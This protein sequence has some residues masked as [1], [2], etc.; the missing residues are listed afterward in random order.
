[1]KHYQAPQD[2]LKERVILVTGAGQGIGRV[3]ALTFAAHGATVILHGRSVKKLEA[4]YDEI[5]AAGHPQPAIFP[6]DLEKAESKDYE[7]LA[8]AIRGQLGRLDGILHNAAVAERPQRLED[9]TLEQWLTLLRVNLAAP[10]ALT[11]ACLPLLKGSPDASVIMTSETHGHA[12]AAYWGGFAV[13]KSGLETLV[14]IWSQELEIHPNVRINALIPGPVQS[15][16]R[17]RT[18]PGEDRRSLPTPESLMP[19]YLYLMGGDSANVSG[20]ILSAQ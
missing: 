18:H 13:A 16:Q 11:R 9:Q 3:A 6:L 12:P 5:E 7:G 2:L 8:G 15:P 17:S 20:K 19:M 1:M 4:V 14:T 10:F